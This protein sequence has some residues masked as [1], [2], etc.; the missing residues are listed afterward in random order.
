LSDFVTKHESPAKRKRENSETRERS[1]SPKVQKCEEKSGIAEVDLA[2]KIKNPLPN[3]FENV[4]LLVEHGGEEEFAKWIRYFT[5]YGGILLKPDKWEEATHVLHLEDTVTEQNI[6]CSKSARHVI[7]EWI[8]DTV[9]NGS[10]QDFRPY[11]VRWE[12]LED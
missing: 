10:L 9:S 2:N 4:K 11:S 12:P 8:K 1:P 7:V 3:I 6:K 5:A